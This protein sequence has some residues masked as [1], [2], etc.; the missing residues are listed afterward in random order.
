MA[1]QGLYSLLGQATTSQYRKDRREEKKYRRDLERDRM[2]AMLLQPVISAAATTGMQAVTDVLGSKFLE[3][4]GRSFTDTEKGR[5]LD[6]KLTSVRTQIA[7][8]TK[9]YES[10]NT[11]DAYQKMV[12][13]LSDEKIFDLGGKVTDEQKASIKSHFGA[14]ENKDNVLSGINDAK[15]NI[16]EQL[17]LLSKAPTDAD[18]A[19]R[20]KNTKYYDGKS[21][22]SKLI[23]TGFNKLLGKDMDTIKASSLN[24]LLTGSEDED[25]TTEISELLKDPSNKGMNALALQ[26]QDLL[27]ADD[28]F[29]LAS[30]K[31]IEEENSEFY[32]SIREEIK[33]NTATYLSGIKFYSVLEKTSQENPES[34]LFNFVN[35]SLYKEAKK[36]NSPEKF[37]ESIS[38]FLFSADQEKFKGFKKRVLLNES[39][40]TKR[41]F[42]LD[43]LGINLKDQ[44]ERDESTLTRNVNSIL[45]S[46]L[47]DAF[48]VFSQLSTQGI[49]DTTTGAI[50][51][52]ILTNSTEEQVRLAITKYSLESEVITGKLE[53]VENQQVYLGS[54]SK[55][56]KQQRF[57]RTL[58]L[59]KNEQYTSDPKEIAQQVSEEAILKIMKEQI[60]PNLTSIDEGIEDIKNNT[61]L[62]PNEK[63]NRLNQI[64]DNALNLATENI[65]NSSNDPSIIDAVTANFDTIFRTMDDNFNAE[66]PRQRDAVAVD[67]RLEINRTTAITNIK[68][69]SDLIDSLTEGYDVDS[70]LRIRNALVSSN[71]N[72]ED[73]KV[74]DAIDN[75][76]AEKPKSS[77]MSTI[78]QQARK[79]R[80]SSLTPK[81]NF[82]EMVEYPEVNPSLLSRSK[83]QDSLEEE[84]DSYIFPLI[85]DA[86]SIIPDNDKF[87]PIPTDV[88]KTILDIESNPKQYTTLEKRNKASS[89]HAHG[90]GQLKTA[91]AVS[92]GYGVPNIFKTAD[93]LGIEYDIDLKAEAIKQQKTNAANN[94]GVKPITGKA[95]KEII[96]LLEMSNVNLTFSSRYLSRLYGKYDGDLEKT[97]LAYNQGPG[98][99]DKWDGNRKNIP[100]KNSEG[101]DYLVKFDNLFNK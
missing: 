99:A 60:D 15:S 50:T 4:G 37:R 17:I 34:L 42:L 97:L 2:K 20:L 69:K 74:T 35:T 8:L 58:E 26:S 68:E 79:K 51:G 63:N 18:L 71:F 16:M 48:N 70:S 93:E 6:K 47:D 87:K 21:K 91:T 55:E 66:F 31:R 53:G 13:R 46:T 41:G 94:N 24:Y 27:K 11:P 38:N 95:G 64:T 54:E 19:S 1:E 57:L 40:S 84:P 67:E 25:F 62:T 56:D 23:S 82:V 3:G 9:E 81:S 76:V 90:I 83:D 65:N 75:A 52:S 44:A 30:L 86:L 85:N 96:R 5:I 36:S 12:K 22:L 43:K 39:F 92:P 61:L 59:V 101:L 49:K 28:N 73:K 88:F 33:D 89:G 100:N 72:P 80:E 10:L 77:L 45:D 32:G 29:V 78:K 98:V 14:T 7:S